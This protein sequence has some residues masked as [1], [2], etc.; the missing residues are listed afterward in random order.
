MISHE[1]SKSAENSI[2]PSLVRLEE[3]L[4]SWISAITVERAQHWPLNHEKV[5]KSCVSLS[6]AAME[7]YYYGCFGFCSLSELNFLRN[8]NY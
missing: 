7:S 5:W 8:W 4:G 1:L 6:L 2:G 3:G